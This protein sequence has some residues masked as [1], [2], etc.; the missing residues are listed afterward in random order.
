MCGSHRKV[1]GVEY[2]KKLKFLYDW[3]IFTYFRLPV[4]PFS[5]H[6]PFCCSTLSPFLIHFLLCYCLQINMNIILILS[7]KVNNHGDVLK[8][9]GDIRYHSH[10][11]T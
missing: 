5:P 1:L 2:E 9:T 3:Y 8:L 11:I 4:V 6:I 10:P 7:T